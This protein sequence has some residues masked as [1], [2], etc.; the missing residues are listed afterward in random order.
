MAE[1]Q[2]CSDDTGGIESGIEAGEP[3]IQTLKNELKALIKNNRRL[4]R[5]TTKVAKLLH[6]ITN[7]SEPP[8]E[9]ARECNICF[10]EYSHER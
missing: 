5:Q 10:E 2:G 1:L 9:N 4:I 3:D 7:K 6:Q 8:V